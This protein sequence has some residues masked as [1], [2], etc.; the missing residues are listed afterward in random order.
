[1]VLLDVNMPEMSGLEILEKLAPQYALCGG[2]VLSGNSRTEDVVLG[3]DTGA[4]DYIRK[5]FDPR[6]LCARVRTSAAYQD[7]NDELRE[8]KCSSQR[9]GRHRRFDR[10]FLTCVRFIGGLITSWS[11]AEDLRVRFVQL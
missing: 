1:V 2:H 8:A 11:A 9:I 4:D 5:P 3:L 7:L 10:T 6:E